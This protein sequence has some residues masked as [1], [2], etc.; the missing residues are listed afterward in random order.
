MP[1]YLFK[2]Q[3]L[4]VV[5]FALLF[6]VFF[7][8]YSCSEEPTTSKGELATVEERVS[9]DV[10][11]FELAEKVLEA[12]G[13]REAWDNTRYIHWNFFGMRELLW[14]KWE[15]KVRIDSK[16]PRI[17]A[18][19][20]LKTKEGTIRSALSNKLGKDVLRQKVYEIW[21]NDS[22]WLVLPFK[23]L[24]PGVRLQYL[25]RDSSGQFEQIELTFDTV[26]LTPQNKYILSIDP[27]NNRII[28]WSYFA[29]AEDEKARFTMA[30]G[31]YG[32]YGD[33]WLSANRGSN[34]S[35]SD[36]WVA[37]DIDSMVMKD[38]DT[39]IPDR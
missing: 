21:V 23:L 36:I 3:T 25:G 29:D 1:V 10:K 12:A 8:I 15:Q 11:A 30:W 2:G 24:D 34:R 26:G 22:Y 4:K 27:S 18:I 31:G 16:S 19:L 37:Q 13:G 9:G 6:F 39:P 28:E 33:I 20:D 14:D 35:I 38:L 17:E 5:H 32:Q 7:G